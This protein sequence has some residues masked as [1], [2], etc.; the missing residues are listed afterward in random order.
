M[1]VEVELLVDVDDVDGRVVD[2]AEVFVVLEEVLGRVVVLAVV[3]VLVTVVD[4]VVRSVVVDVEGRVVCVVELNV[5]DVEEVVVAPPATY[6]SAPVSGR[7][8]RGCPSMSV[9]GPPGEPRSIAA[10]ASVRW[11]SIGET[12]AGG[13]ANPWTSCDPCAALKLD[14]VS[15]VPT[16]GAPDVPM[17][18]IV[19]AS[20]K[21]MFVPSQATPLQLGHAV[22]LP[23]RL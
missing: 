22:A 1:L 14:K 5:V 21:R 8:S 6:S 12:N 19:A 10:L 16:V 15:Q 17:A 4:V 11:G 7:A 2:V 18:G 20:R 23:Y 9:G 13:P 3:D